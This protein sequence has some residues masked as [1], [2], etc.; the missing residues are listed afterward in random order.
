ML[1]VK[2]GHNLFKHGTSLDIIRYE[3]TESARPLWYL[4]QSKKFAPEPAST[5]QLQDWHTDDTDIPLQN[6][7][8][9]SDI[10]NMCEWSRHLKK[11]TVLILDNCNHILHSKNREH[12]L[13]VISKHFSNTLITIIMTSQEKLLLLH[14]DFYPLTIS[15]L[16][17]NDSR[18]MLQHY[19]PNLT[20]HVADELSSADLKEQAVDTIS[21]HMYMM[22]DKERFRVIMDIAYRQMDNKT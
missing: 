8:S 3:D 14:S 9:L 7:N 20:D 17:A 13:K 21:S 18:Q 6:K 15:E 2:L 1:A 16:T 5:T 11:R 4:C 22:S 12:F 10:L 19:V